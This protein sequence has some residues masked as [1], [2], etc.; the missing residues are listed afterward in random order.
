MVDFAQISGGDASP[1]GVVFR[2]GAVPRSLQAMDNWALFR[3]RL[4]A[5]NQRYE[6][7]PLRC[8][9]VNASSTDPSTWSPFASICNAWDRG[10]SLVDPYDG[11]GFMLPQS[12]GI[13]V[14][15][16]DHCIDLPTGIIEPAALELVAAFPT[17]WERSPSGTGLHGWMIAT[18]SVG[19][20]RATTST[21]L[22]IEIYSHSRFMTVTGDKLER[23]LRDLTDCQAALDALCEALFPRQA[24]IPLDR[25]DSIAVLSAIENDDDLI[26]TASTAGNYQKFIDLF[27]HGDTSAYGGD[28]SAADMALICILVFWC[29]RDTERVDRL[30]RRSKLYRDKWN[31]KRGETTYGAITIAAGMALVTEFYEPGVPLIAAS[32]R[33]SQ[34]STDVSAAEQSGQAPAIGSQDNEPELHP[35]DDPTYPAPPPPTILYGPLGEFIQ[36]IDPT[37]EA[38]QYATLL[39]SIVVIGSIIGR[40]A[41]FMIDQTAHYPNLFTVVVGRT[42]TGRKGTGYSLARWL[43]TIIDPEWAATRIMNGLSS[44]E[45]LIANV[46]DP[47]LKRIVDKNTGAVTFEETDPGVPD[48]RLLVTETE[49]AAVLK[50]SKRDGNNLSPVLRQ[51]WDGDNLRTM[52]KNSPYV[53][54][55]PHVS[56]IGH[57]TPEELNHCL[58]YTEMFNGFINRYI[59]I[60]SRRSKF[61]AEPL[62]PDH[63]AVNRIAARIA[64]SI[65][66]ANCLGVMSRSPA[67]A[68][69]WTKIYKDLNIERYGI[70][71]ALTTRAPVQIMRI[72]MIYAIV[73]G[74]RSIETRHLTAASALWDYSE[75]CAGH[76]FGMSF[77]DDLVDNLYAL[78]DSRGISR[79][80]IYT[81]FGRHKSRAQI[82]RG[83]M[84]LRRLDA[85]SEE[86]VQTAGRPRIVYKRTEKGAK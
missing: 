63:M 29:G 19:K 45:G 10:R 30:F 80:E 46:R 7:A 12:G 3:L 57:I 65:A 20:S 38:D 64:K 56:V 36:V 23:C 81:H 76:L 17:Y 53:A 48:K 82:D 68:D 26:A 1:N 59:W 5:R 42:G 62:S 40:K 37:T 73:D 74:S 70:M 34:A 21:G 83:L 22:K 85:I 47:I 75:R 67:C 49:F 32:D 66:D 61:L 9:G 39:E 13:V 33:R 71:G 84:L 86:H 41:H 44:G 58:E 72:A 14:I 79:M 43:G 2:R 60:L 31:E 24:E 51:A 8:S 55:N 54:T 16:I 78:M 25:Q 15:D 4:D 69:L 35:L 50:I 28:D 11:A 77:G 27:Y 18:K 52:T 6:K